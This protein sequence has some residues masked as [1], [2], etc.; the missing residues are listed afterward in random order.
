MINPKR[1]TDT[2]EDREDRLFPYYAGYSSRF[3]RRLLSS[4][5]LG[6]KSIVLDPW[7]GS[8]TTTRVASALKLPTVGLDLNPAMV[9]IAKADLMAAAEVPALHPLALEISKRALER[10]GALDPTDPLNKWMI[11]SSAH[12]VRSVERQIRETLVGV[13]GSIAVLTDFQQVS[14]LTALM[15][16]GLFRTTRRLLARFVATNPT[17]VKAPATQAHRLRPTPSDVVQA[18]QAEVAL[19]A[20]SVASRPA[21]T[22]DT[23]DARLYR[24]SSTRMPLPDGSVDL[25]LT[26]PPY[27]T[28]IDYA[29]ATSIELAVLGLDAN[30]FDTLRRSLL[31][32]S[33]VPSDPLTS[34]KG[35]LGGTCDALLDAI[36]RHQSRASASYYLKSHQQYF[37]GLDKSLAEISRVTKSGG[38]CIA[39]VQDSFYKEIHN[40]LP[41]IFVEAAAKHGLALAR[42]ED[43]QSSRSMVNLNTRSRQYVAKRQTMESVLILTRH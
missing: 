10:G 16:L 35:R 24:A 3:T 7:N 40:D 36:K 1:G 21:L 30:S 12:I 4:L 41:Q 2:P 29:V 23:L 19:L 17:W 5:A 37:D 22:R 13:S 8:G 15:Y 18:F 20:L 42:R 33:T 39:I 6:P 32:T 14:P 26:S 38:G 31:G 25:V 9:V 11:P 28:R 43:F 34:S 27:C